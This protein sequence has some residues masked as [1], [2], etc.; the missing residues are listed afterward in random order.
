MDPNS[1]AALLQRREA[2][3]LTWRGPA[4]MLLARAA[5]AVAA[6][7]VVAGVFALRSSSAPWHD[8]E[9][10]LPVYGTLI[11][12]GCLVLLWHL[13]RREG[14]RLF[15]LVGFERARVVRDTLLGLALVPASLVFILGGIY[16]AG[17]LLYG[18]LTPPYLFG[19]LPLPAA[20]Y[21][22]LVFPFVWGLTEQMTYNGYLVPRLQVL[23]RST[24]LAVACVAFAWSLQHAFMPLTF[25]AKFMTFR[26]LSAVPNTVFQTVLYLRL[27]RLIPFALA[28]AL[29]DGASVLMGALLPQL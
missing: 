5:C 14:M 21:G 22:V 10:W 8:A 17:W 27:R 16:G 11:D 26:A 13:T 9:P 20:L 24:T 18:T 28:H 4:L 19:T 7:G 15:Q 25:D 29:M 1:R 12:A 3:S 2:A 6:Q 23:C